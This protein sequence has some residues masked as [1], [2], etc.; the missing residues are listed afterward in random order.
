MLTVL[1]RKEVMVK[2]RVIRMP[3]KKGR[4]GGEVMNEVEG[5]FTSNGDVTMANGDV[6]VPLTNGHAHDEGSEQKEA[7]TVNGHG[8]SRLASTNGHHDADS[9]M[10][11][12]GSTEAGIA[13]GYGHVNGSA[14][15]PDSERKRPRLESQA[16]TNGES[17]PQHDS[18]PGHWDLKMSDDEE[19]EDEEDEQSTDVP[20]VDEGVAWISCMAA[21]EDGQWLAVSDLGG[22]I[23][24]YNL[25]TLR[26]SRLEY[27]P[28]GTMTESC[29]FSSTLH[30]PHSPSHPPR[31]PFPL[32]THLYSPCSSPPG[33]S[34]S[35][36]SR[37]ADYSPPPS[38]F[39]SSTTPCGRNTPPS[40][41]PRS[42]PRDP[43]PARRNSSSGRTT[44]SV[45]PGSTWT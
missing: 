10:R 8:D 3:K 13:N 20:I 24:V 45:P 15:K 32:L 37:P 41:P 17:P 19:E 31:S 21:S 29:L 30:F 34:P 28:D 6:A 18:E 42:S 43:I 23:S 14:R 36:L 38:N 22:K 39:R 4:R 9:E 27:R 2:G 11:G 25:D 33:L 1:A 44:G 26:V 16:N 7:E 35:T 12:A 5:I 40:N